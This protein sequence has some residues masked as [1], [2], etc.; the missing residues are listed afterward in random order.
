MEVGARGLPCHSQ[1][2]TGAQSCGGRSSE[3]LYIGFPLI[4]SIFRLITI[5]VLVINCICLL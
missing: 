2:R 5:T 3:V 1:T 4:E